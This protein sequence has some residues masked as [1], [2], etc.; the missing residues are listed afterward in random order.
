MVSHQ[1]NAVKTQTP[2]NVVLP[3]QATERP[4]VFQQISNINQQ[5]KVEADNE[6]VKIEQDSSNV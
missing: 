5:I 6:T 1:T 4:D 2:N 3:Y